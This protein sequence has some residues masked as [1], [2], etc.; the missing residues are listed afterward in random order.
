MHTLRGLAETI[1]AATLARLAGELEEYLKRG[2][3]LDD[4]QIDKLL[5]SLESALPGVLALADGIGEPP[6]GATLAPVAIDEALSNL[7]RLLDNDDAQAVRLFDD[8]ALWLS[9]ESDAM[10]VD[11]LRQQIGRYDFELAAATLQQITT[12][13]RHA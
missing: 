2:S 13:L 5:A 1:G 11:Q 4:G 8:I 6:A 12:K 10:L 7:Q 9:Q 3:P